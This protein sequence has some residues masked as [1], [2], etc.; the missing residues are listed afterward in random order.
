M[1]PRFESQPYTPSPPVAWMEDDLETASKSNGMDARAGAPKILV[2]DDS[3]PTARALASLL[4]DSGYDTAVSHQG[5]GALT[6]ADTCTP[7]AAVI[8]IHLPDINGLVL[9]QKL[10]E[11]FGPETPIIMLSGDNS[12]ETL[13][14][15]S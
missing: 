14:S 3:E 1:L 11:S 15:L 7:A 13:K 4:H 2:V 6:F 8:D 12:M 9:C 5:S 10:R